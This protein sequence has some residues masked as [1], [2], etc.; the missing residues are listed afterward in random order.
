MKKTTFLIISILLCCGFF[1]LNIFTTLVSADF[2]LILQWVWALF[3]IVYYNDNRKN[4]VNTVQNKFFFYLFCIGIVLSMFSA[5]IYHEQALLNTA[6]SQRAIYNFIYFFVFLIVHPTEKELMYSLKYGVFF[7]IV[8]FGLSVFFPHIFVSNDYIDSRIDAEN[9]DLGY[10]QTGMLISLL[11]FYYL[12]NKIMKYNS[13]KLF[14]FLTIIL[15]YFILLQN[16]SVLI[17]VVPVYVFTAIKIKGIKKIGVYLF[18]IFVFSFALSFVN[19]IFNYLLEETI[20]QLEDSNY[21]RWQAIE[22]F[23]YEFNEGNIVR[24]IFGNGK[25][26]FVGDYIDKLSR[27][28]IER[29]AYVSDIGL[30]G[31][32][33][34]YG[35][36]PII[37][38]IVIGGQIIFKKT[39]S[40]YLKI[41]TCHLFIVPTIF[42]F[43]SSSGAFL[44]SLY[45]Y[46][47]LFYNSYVRKTRYRSI[48]NYSKL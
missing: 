10:V 47:Y 26:T 15:L 40:N 34:L 19:K 11:Y 32:W 23:V 48:S 20:S 39:F 29:G 25:P 16:R 18:A 1:E 21:N 12:A 28:V 24:Q 33:F 37:V 42:T 36:I 41:F 46:L 8:F 4:A 45:F 5:L 38:I 7:T 43:D 44:F 30:I 9:M 31:N 22:F 6:I 27:A 35:V 3:G 13:L 17:L 14:A 2:F